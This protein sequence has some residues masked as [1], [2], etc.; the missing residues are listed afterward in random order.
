M[1]KQR[2]FRKSLLLIIPGMVAWMLF[3]GNTLIASAAGI[4]YVAPVGSD[5][6]TCVSSPC[7]TIAYA[8]GQADAGDTISIAAG[9]YKEP[10]TVV[11]DK[12]LTFSG[13][14]TAATVIDGDNNKRVFTTTTETTPPTLVFSDLTI[15]NGSDAGE[16]KYA[17]GAGVYAKGG[18]TLTN[19][20]VLSNTTAAKIANPGRVGGGGVRVFGELH[21]TGGEFRNNSTTGT[22]SEGGAICSGSFNA[23]DPHPSSYILGAVFSDNK[24]KYGGGISAAGGLSLIDAQFLNNSATINGG[25][26]FQTDATTISSTHISRGYFEKNTASTNGGAV[27]TNR[28]L[29]VSDT[30]FIN[31]TSTPNR[32]GGLFTINSPQVII[33]G[34]QFANNTSGAGGGLYVWASNADAGSLQV[35]ITN[36]RF[37]GN[38]ATN[39]NGGGLYTNS[40]LTLVNTQF[41]T[42]T[43]TPFSGGGAYIL[44]YSYSSGYIRPVVSI[45]DTKFLTN[46]AVS[47]GGGL[48]STDSSSVVITD[49]EFRGNTSGGGGGLALNSNNNGYYYTLKLTNTKFL[50]NTS[51]SK[52]GGLWTTDYS[53]SL[54][55]LN[56][57]F[58]NNAAATSGGGLYTAAN[59]TLTDT[60]LTRN[61]AQDG[62]G[63]YLTI[64]RYN[65]SASQMTNVLLQANGARSKGGALYLFPYYNNL[66][67]KGGTINILNTTIAS[68]TVS[69]AP[70]IYVSKPSTLYPVSAN[71]TNT[72]VSSY[73]IGIEA[74]K[75]ASAV[76]AA[77]AIW[78]A[79]F[80][81]NTTIPISGSSVVSNTSAIGDPAF[82]NL[83]AGDNRLSGFSEAIDTGLNA[84][85]PLTDLRGKAR[86][87]SACDIGAYEFQDSDLGGGD[88]MR[89][90]PK[91]GVT[92]TYRPLH[93]SI[94]LT[95][96]DL[97]RVLIRKGSNWN[98][99]H[100]SAIL[101]HWTITPEHPNGGT[102]TIQLCWQS[103]DLNGLLPADLIKFWRWTGSSWANSYTPTS[104]DAATPGCATLQGVSE[105]SAWTLGKDANPTVVTLR[106]LNATAHEAPPIA[107]ALV[108]V[109]AL[110]ALLCTL[111]I[112]RRLNRENR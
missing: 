90:T 82:I 103:G 92:H 95:S 59:L 5:T 21:V 69:A 51:S 10:T 71:I 65:A 111:W 108:V 47:S 22:S 42:N 9:V 73:T 104:I 52:G 11:I 84:P 8:V 1:H 3:L 85:C 100:S 112:G 17:S 30:Q 67:A 98:G 78:N 74:E 48:S 31:N 63:V 27:Y 24:S 36:T 88:T 99:P 97:G 80:F 53:G 41:I 77:V 60:Q 7:A 106:E 46:T 43:A 28:Y 57:Q 6:G 29:T 76:G 32:G 102:A 34:T 101:P 2:I 18:L 55:V 56:S 44:N 35:I 75:N 107:G 13:A 81:A 64:G 20:N 96:G 38:A 37:T 83:A 86:D 54:T 58:I 94:R 70:A 93:I 50:T 40:S 109:L 79:L 14:G 68:P 110:L 23:S 33:T 15:Q 45:R 62:G 4:H 39:S 25:A 16:T 26:V 12:S 105:F 87:D 66:A 19:V 91:L 49:T 89:A 61:S 72:I